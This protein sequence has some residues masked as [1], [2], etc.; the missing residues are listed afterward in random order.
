VVPNGISPCRDR[1]RAELVGW[2][3][4]PEPAPT[5]SRS[6]HPVR[7]VSGTS[8]GHGER[9]QTL[10]DWIAETRGSAARRRRAQFL[11]ACATE[12]RP[13]LPSCSIPRERDS[14]WDGSR[15]M[16]DVVLCAVASRSRV[17][18][19]HKGCVVRP[20]R[21]VDPRNCCGVRSLSLWIIAHARRRF[22][23]IRSDPFTLDSMAT[24][25][26]GR[27][28]Q[29]APGGPS[30]QTASQRDAIH[31]PG[32]YSTVSVARPEHI[33]YYIWRSPEANHRDSITIAVG[34]VV[35]HRCVQCPDGEWR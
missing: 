33:G 2:R 21:W 12:L 22:L 32:C 18:T 26:T 13:R 28:Q 14:R 15:Q 6:G 3:L 25:L 34:R 16:S 17:R 19:F 9:V 8:R 29:P 35:V 27:G 10:E 11:R 5:G 30:S 20:P 1:R 31:C 23:L 24:A 4:T 7:R